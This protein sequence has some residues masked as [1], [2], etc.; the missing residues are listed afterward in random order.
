MNN[1]NT[2]YPLNSHLKFEIVG[3]GRCVI[4]NSTLHTEIEQLSAMGITEKNWSCERLW[5]IKNGKGHLITSFGEFD[6]VKGLAYYLPATSILDAYCED[7]IEFLYIDFNPITDGISLNSIYTFDYKLENFSLI[8][9]LI[10]TVINEHTAATPI[11]ETIINNAMSTLLSLFI[12]EIKLAS[13]PQIVSAMNY[14]NEHFTEKINI[15]ALAKQL[16][17]SPEYFCYRFKKFFNIS[18]QQF[19]TQKRIS[20]AKQLLETTQLPISSIAQ[21]CGYQDP[22]YFSRVFTKFCAASPS[23]FRKSD[24][25]YKSNL[26]I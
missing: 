5:V 6:V 11:S 22:L 9:N 24:C 17:I 19:I 8:S 23:E 2:S 20:L 15:S 21:H 7:F 12:K 4:D 13:S 3:C 25:S 16:Y 26:K 18:P 1:V 14:I 10:K